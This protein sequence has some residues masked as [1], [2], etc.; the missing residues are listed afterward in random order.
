MVKSVEKLKFVDMYFMFFQ[1]GWTEEDPRH[2]PVQLLQQ[3]GLADD[4]GHADTQR[5]E[6]KT[7]Y[8][9]ASLE[10]NK[11]DSLP[12]FACFIIRLGS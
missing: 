7:Y 8:D 1:L 6:F 2:L 11:T 5:R 12:S 10:R 3:R 9:W 4:D